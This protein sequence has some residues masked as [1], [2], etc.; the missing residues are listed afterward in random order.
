MSALDP[1]LS[2][3]VTQELNFE[4]LSD[5]ETGLASPFEIDPQGA[6]KTTGSFDFELLAYYPVRIRVRDPYGGEMEKDFNIEVMDMH[7]PIVETNL[8]VVEASGGVLLSGK[9]LDMGGNT[10][11][12][13]LGILVSLAPITDPGDAA[14]EKRILS[15]DQAGEF[16]GYYYPQVSGTVYYTLA[17]GENAEA[18]SYT[19]LTLPTT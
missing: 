5:P 10:G 8:P 15:I 16:S 9:V 1:D 13:E 17:Y 6:L 4:I 19:H 7:T 11:D 2:E 18:V 3:G 14:V 12:L